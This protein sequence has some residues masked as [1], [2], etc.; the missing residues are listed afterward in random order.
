MVWHGWW[1]VPMRDVS[2]IVR[3]NCT[4]FYVKRGWLEPHC[5]YWLTSLI[6]LV[7]LPYKKSERLWT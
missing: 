3:E 1:T 2:G 6:S 5:L 7:H 4:P